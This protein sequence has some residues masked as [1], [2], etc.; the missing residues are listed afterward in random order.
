MPQMLSCAM[1]LSCQIAERKADFGR[2]EAMDCGKPL[3]EALWDMVRG[4]DAH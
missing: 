1:S 2:A 3:D 4:G